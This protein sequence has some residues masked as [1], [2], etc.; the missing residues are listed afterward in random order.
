[1]D[2]LSHSCKIWG[3]GDNKFSASTEDMV[4]LAVTK[5]LHKPEVTMNRAVFI[6]SFEI[7]MN[8]LLAAYKT[9]TGVAD[10]EVTYGDIE[11][12][13]RVAREK[14]EN[15]KPSEEK[16]RALGFLAHAIGLKEG[17]GADFVAAGLSDNELLELPHDDL[18]STIAKILREREGSHFVSHRYQ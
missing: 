18:T 15:T 9:A 13:I 5:I 8:E 17:L 12:G 7:S 16:S 6:S 4:A 3:N 10:W 2:P 1:M 11:E 14:F